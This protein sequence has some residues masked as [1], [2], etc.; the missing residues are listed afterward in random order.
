[1]RDP[2]RIP[3]IIQFL[4]QHWLENP[5]LRLG[6]IIGNAQINYYTE[7]EAALEKLRGVDQL[8]RDHKESRNK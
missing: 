2:N 8:I 5:D 6:Q 7:D 1:M 4:A 3:E